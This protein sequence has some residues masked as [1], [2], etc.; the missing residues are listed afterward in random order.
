MQDDDKETIYSARIRPERA[1]NK[2]TKGREI[3]STFLKNGKENMG[4]YFIRGKRRAYSMKPYERAW[5]A[6][7]I[8]GEGTIGVYKCH[9]ASR[10]KE[11]PYSYTT[12]VSIANTDAR[13]CLRA[14]HITKLGTVF[15]NYSNSRRAKHHKVYYIWNTSRVSFLCELLP[16]LIIKNEQAR[17]AILAK[18]LLA[19]HKSGR[20]GT[21]NDQ[22]LDE[23]C[24]AIKF[25][26]GSYER[27][28]K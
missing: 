28:A 14:L 3:A 15:Q 27:V 21:P 26:N 5:L 12:H 6:A 4:N 18:Q 25:Y 7:A 10:N 17:L 20:R 24:R 9:S 2:C 22:Q 13:F 16:Y 23:I 19:P 8:D 1:D 11:R